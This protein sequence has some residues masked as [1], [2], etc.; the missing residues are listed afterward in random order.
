MLGADF[1]S[2]LY[3]EVS[4]RS[5]REKARLLS[6]EVEEERG[7]ICLMFSYQLRTEGVASLR[8]LLRDSDH[9]ETLLW[10]LR[11]DQGPLWREGRTILPRSPKEYQVLYL[12][13]PKWFKQQQPF[14]SK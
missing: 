11:G 2:Y 7:P 10:A 9:Q 5:E 13:L 4:P 1:G 12:H 6:P 3:A 14:H 8:V